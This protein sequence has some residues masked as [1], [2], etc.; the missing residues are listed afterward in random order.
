MGLREAVA[1]EREQQ[2]G[3]CTE[4]PLLHSLSKLANSFFRKTQTIL[5]LLLLVRPLAP[6]S[7]SCCRQVRQDR[8]KEGRLRPVLTCSRK[9]SM[10]AKHQ[11]QSEPP[12]PPSPTEPL[13]S[14]EDTQVP[15]TFPSSLEMQVP[16]RRPL[17][18]HPPRRILTDPH[19]TPASMATSLCKPLRLPC[20]FSL[21]LPV[22][23]S[24]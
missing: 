19:D 9:T 15:T 23:R 5:L 10:R 24:P 18:P 20:A 11:H 3:L 4:A 7:D 17:P 8:E 12:N 21:I 2:G 6:T 22:A 1:S 14:R 13:A 16:S